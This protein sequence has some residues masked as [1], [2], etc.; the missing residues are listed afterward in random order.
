MS[1]TTHPFFSH[2]LFGADYYGINTWFKMQIAGKRII[3]LVHFTREN[4][5]EKAKYAAKG[6]E[7]LKRLTAAEGYLAEVDKVTNTMA[8]AKT[9]ERASCCYRCSVFVCVCVCVCV[10]ARCVRAHCV[11]VFRMGSLGINSLP[12]PSLELVCVT[13]YSYYA[14]T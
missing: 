14:L 10:R 2:N 1:L 8:G 5:E 12:M 6:A 11:A 4:D 13:V 7:I 3:K 9:N